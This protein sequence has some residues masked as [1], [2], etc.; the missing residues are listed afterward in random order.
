MYIDK[1]NTISFRKLIFILL[2][3]LFRY[4]IIAN[5]YV[6]YIYTDFIKI[7]KLIDLKNTQLQS[8]SRLIKT[9]KN[10]K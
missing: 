8:S 2:Y 10:I 9:Y 1:R 7:K 3:L 4:W 6:S 5:T